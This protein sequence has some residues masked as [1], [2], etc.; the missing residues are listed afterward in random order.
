[1]NICHHT[2]VADEMQTVSRTEHYSC[3]SSPF[4]SSPHPS[5]YQ[6]VGFSIFVPLFVSPSRSLL[7]NRFLN[8]TRSQSILLFL[9][10]VLYIPSP[11]PPCF[12]CALP[13]FF[14]SCFPHSLRPSPPFLYGLC[15]L[16]QAGP[17]LLERESVADSRRLVFLAAVTSRHTQSTRTKC[18]G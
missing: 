4:S 3:L 2:L 8:P 10:I 7:Y 6:P 11:P 5:L 15:L 13:S 17:R 18:L 12:K 14:A 16:V 1:M 9:S